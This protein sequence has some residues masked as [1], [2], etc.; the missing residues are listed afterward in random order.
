MPYALFEENERLPRSFAT[1]QEVW[2]AAER[3]SLVI[4][5]PDGVKV[6]D[7]NYE[8]KPCEDTTGEVID[9]GSDFIV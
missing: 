1:Q 4:I 3:A 8:I 9:P 2:D 5:G 6:L 7:D